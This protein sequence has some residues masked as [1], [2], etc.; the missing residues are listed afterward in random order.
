MRLSCIQEA[1]SQSGPGGGGRSHLQGVGGHVYHVRGSLGVVLLLLLLLAGG[2]LLLVDGVA[3]PLRQAEEAA[4][5]GQ[6]LPQ[7]AVLRGRLLLP[8]QQL[9]Q[10]AL[11]TRDIGG[12][13]GVGG[14]G[15]REKEGYSCSGLKCVGRPCCV[16]RPGLLPRTRRQTQRPFIGASTG[17]TFFFV[18]EDDYV[19]FGT[20]NTKQERNMKR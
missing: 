9:T 12:E 14:G 10:P 2:A 19:F 16:F 7:S 13:Q 18:F 5:H 20:I 17:I 11:R 3:L 4:D 1:G 8:A 15:E 6:V